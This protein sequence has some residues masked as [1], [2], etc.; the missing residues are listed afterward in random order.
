MYQRIDTAARHLRQDLA[1][2]LASRYTWAQPPI[3]SSS[4][5]RNSDP[6][7][8]GRY[9]VIHRL[10]KGGFG[11]VYLAHT[12]TPGLGNGFGKHRGQHTD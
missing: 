2:H 1:R 12:S 3:D 4:G 8:I 10:G 9:Q 7:K 5:T 11:R 6:S